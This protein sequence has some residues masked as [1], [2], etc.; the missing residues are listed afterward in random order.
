MRLDGGL[1]LTPKLLGYSQ[2][3]DGNLVINP[4]EESTVKLV[5]YMY[6]Y[7]YSTAEIADAL[8]EL[9]KKTYLGNV[10]WTSNSVVQVLRNER[11]CGDVLTRKTYTPN[12]LNHKARKNRGDR[13]QSIYRNHHVLD[14]TLRLCVGTWEGDMNSLSANFL[15]GV[16]RLVV[17]FGDSIR[18][19]LFKEKVGFMSV[20][21][22][23]RTAKER[24]PGSI[25]Y[26]EAMLVAYN[27]KCKYPLRWNRLYEKNLV[28][29]DGLD[30]DVALPSDEVDK[31]DEPD[32]AGE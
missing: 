5:F 29:T 14:R 20:K 24:R 19:D 21:Q 16:A 3:A 4:D 2:D 9:G 1:P 10:N 6:L 27:R 30:V 7:G 8:T 13:P 28:T 15:N 31:T 12:Y 17:A 18:D 32:N 11:H 22:L 26:S 23:S 25:G